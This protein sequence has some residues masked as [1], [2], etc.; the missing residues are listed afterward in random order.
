M[1]KFK[2]YIPYMVA[3]A[4]CVFVTFPVVSKSVILD[5]AY[6]ILLVRKS[7]PDII[8]GTAGDVHP[9]LY[10]LILKFFS[11]FGG[12]SLLMYRAATAL[13]T[14]LNLIFLGAT[15]I[16]KR[17]GVRVSVLYMLWF[18]LTF[19]TLERSS[20]IR[21][22][23]WAAFFVTAA[24]LYCFF[25]YESQSK[26]DLAMGIAMTLGAMY[27]H[28]YALLAAF[29]VWVM[30]LAVSLFRKKKTL[31]V[32]AG[33]VIVTAGYLPW[34]GILLTQFRSVAEDYW[35]TSMDWSEWKM[36]PAYLMEASDADPSGIGAVL[37]ALILMTLLTAL[38][39]KRWDALCSAAVFVGTM[40]LA[41]VISVAVTPI[42]TTRYMYVAW[43]MAALFMAITIGETVS[44]YSGLIQGMTVLLLLVVGLHSFQLMMEDETMVSTADEW[45]D[46]LRD[47]VTADACVIFD[48][49]QEHRLVYQ[50]YMPEAAVIG[51]SRLKQGGLQD[52]LADYLGENR[53]KD[54]WYIIDYRQQTLGCD[55]MKNALE[56]LGYT[57]ESRGSFIIKQKTLEIFRVEEAG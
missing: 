36:V 21:M 38:L 48:D 50:Y 53:G 14:W 56:K 2:Q 8:L 37:Y 44:R 12:E 23:S 22:Y 27:T 57:M 19:S 43:G 42:W 47:N 1:A 25:Y 51:V 4:L 7:V 39:R 40:V 17:W 6:S 15:L 34:L 46:F 26:K 16:R 18:G 20:L 41:A 5:E 35:I 10:Y 29:T 33:G 13:A 45:V 30:L 24:A 54:L 11:L 49:P 3:A 55:K 32:L 31:P 9:P 28:Y 52:S